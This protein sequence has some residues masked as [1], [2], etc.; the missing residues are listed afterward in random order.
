[1]ILEKQLG[2]QPVINQTLPIRRRDFRDRK[3]APVGNLHP[4]EFVES[5][6]IETAAFKNRPELWTGFAAYVP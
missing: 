1:M 3:A 6:S 4:A 2:K 5:V